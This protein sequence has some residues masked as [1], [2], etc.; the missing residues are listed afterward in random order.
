MKLFYKTIETEKILKAIADNNR[1]RIINLLIR[2]ELCVC[3]IEETLSLSQTNVSRHLNKLTTAG[4]LDSRKE[5]QWV[6]YRINNNFLTEHSALIDYLKSS[7]EKDDTCRLDTT[8]LMQAQ[9]SQKTGL[10]R[11]CKKMQ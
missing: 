10:S 8:K 11:Q 4:I 9:K 6:F 3:D 2:G 1:L 5:A 7:F